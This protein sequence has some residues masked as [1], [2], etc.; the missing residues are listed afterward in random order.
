MKLYARYVDD[1][2]IVVK[3]IDFN[4]EF[5]DRNMMERLKEIA[6][7]IHQSIRV[8]IDCPSLHED[9]RLPV[10]DLAQWIEEKD[11]DGRQVN[12]IMHSHYMKPMA[13]RFVIRKDSAQSMKAKTNILVS[14]LVRIMRNVSI[15]CPKEERKKHVQYFIWRMQ[16]SGYNENERKAVFLK[17]KRKFE[18]MLEND[19]NRLIPLYRSKF[20]NQIERQEEKARKVRDW[21]KRDGCEAVLFL[22]ATPDEALANECQKILK[23]AKLPI[24]TIERAG[25]SMKDM[26]VKSNPFERRECICEICKRNQR[27]KVN[28]KT[29]NVV[30]EIECFGSKNGEKCTDKYIGETSRSL[31]E[32]FEEHVS[33]NYKRLEK[34][35]MWKHF[36]DDHKGK[37]QSFN[38]KILSST[39][40]DAMLRQITEAMYIEGT[41]PKINSKEEW[42]NKNVPRKRKTN[43]TQQR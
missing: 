30:Y 2:N 36:R 33:D 11:I 39:Q 6:N 27:K 18:T 20:W 4:G 8:A 38:V 26:L 19:K 5:A 16:H 42:G 1:T 43:E 23:D 12:Q 3:A 25:N 9:G 29:R 10:L 31:G 37:D 28:C 32:R 14:D 7:S 22:E 35:V 15:Q 40:N 17:A 21:Y 24:R 13:N 41:N 34:S